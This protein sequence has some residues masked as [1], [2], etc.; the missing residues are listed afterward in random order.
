MTPKCVLLY[1]SQESFHNVYHLVTSV[2]FLVSTSVYSDIWQN[3]MSDNTGGGGVGVGVVGGTVVFVS[4][5]CGPWF[6]GR[7]KL[8]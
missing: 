3:E 8:T 5:Q 6:D 7:Q 2:T 1:N 4:Q